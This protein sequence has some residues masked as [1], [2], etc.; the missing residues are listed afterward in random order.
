[1]VT[2]TLALVTRMSTFVVDIL[3]L[4]S[5]N[6]IQMFWVQLGATIA[7]TR[8]MTQMGCAVCMRSLRAQEESMALWS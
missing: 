1:M 6:I 4:A 3:H 2:R 7:I 5:G 8:S